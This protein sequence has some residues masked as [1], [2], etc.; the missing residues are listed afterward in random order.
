MLTDMYIPNY[1]YMFVYIYIYDILEHVPSLFRAL[2]YCC[3]T[4]LE[5]LFGHTPSCWPSDL[6]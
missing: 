2:A 4:C 3:T 1:K 5:P 6:H